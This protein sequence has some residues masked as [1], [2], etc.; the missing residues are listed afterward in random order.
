M[1]KFHFQGRSGR[2]TLGIQLLAKR[3]ASLSRV[4]SSLNVMALCADIRHREY[5]GSRKLALNRKIVM[6]G[7]SELVPVEVGEFVHRV[8]L[9]KVQVRVCLAAD[10]REG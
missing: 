1:W 10:Y 2:R 7:I 9:G 3:C 4:E 5:R 8:V 6:L